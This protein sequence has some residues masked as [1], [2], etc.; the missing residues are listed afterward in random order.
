MWLLSLEIKTW[1]LIPLQL[2][3]LPYLPCGELCSGPGIVPCQ[4]H[5]ADRGLTPISL[6]QHVCAHEGQ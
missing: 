1:L 6:I 4:Q 3:Y 5:T 2:G